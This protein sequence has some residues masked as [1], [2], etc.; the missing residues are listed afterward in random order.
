[1][2]Q[3]LSAR[4]TFRLLI[5]VVVPA[6]VVAALMSAQQVPAEISPPAQFEAASVKPNR[7]GSLSLEFRTPPGRLTVRNADLRTIVKNAFRIRQDVDLIGGPRWIET[8]RFDITATAPEKTSSDQILLMLQSLLFERF[9]LAVHREPRQVQLYKLRIASGAPK[10]RELKVGMTPRSAGPDTR[11]IGIL[12]KTSG[13]T[14]AL[15][16]FLGRDVIDETGLT[17]SYDL[18]I[19]VAKDD[20]IITAGSADTGDRTGP[21]GP[22]L[23]SA[24]QEQLGLKLVSEKAEVSILVIDHVERPSAN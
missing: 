8:E 10:L 20:P 1:M 12:G 21:A 2:L 3:E 16:K 11:I 18:S 14:R 5:A 19:E 4:G 13:L 24:L 17:G 15:S 9:K 22:S 23:F 6:S 7:S